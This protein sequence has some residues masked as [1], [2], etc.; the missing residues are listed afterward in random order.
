[1]I[2]LIKV[3]QLKELVKPTEMKITQEFIHELN[4]EI[5]NTINKC[6]NRAKQDNR[7][8]LLKRDI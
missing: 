5:T 2:D 7:K 4:Q 6:I 8:T 3:S 1:M